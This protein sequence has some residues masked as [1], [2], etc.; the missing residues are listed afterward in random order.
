MVL[1]RYWPS[2]VQASLDTVR[3]IGNKAAD[4]AEQTRAVELEYYDIMCAPAYGAIP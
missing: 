4:Y 1:P 2:Q 3:T